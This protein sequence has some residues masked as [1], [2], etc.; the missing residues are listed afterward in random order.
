MLKELQK[1]PSDLEH[2]TQ[3]RILR[4]CLGGRYANSRNEL[5]MMLQQLAFYAQP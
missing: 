1:R 5:S 2:L 4:F 3:G